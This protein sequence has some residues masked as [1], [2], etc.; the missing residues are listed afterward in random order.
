VFK[1]AQDARGKA[2]GKGRMGEQNRLLDYTSP[3]VKLRETLQYM[4]QKRV[5][6]KYS[7]ET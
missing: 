5:T 6:Y 7:G 3:I 4:F 1:K 2:N